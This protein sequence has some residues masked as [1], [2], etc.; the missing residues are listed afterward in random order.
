VAEGEFVPLCLLK[1][2]KSFILNLLVF[3][4]SDLPSALPMLPPV[5]LA[6]DLVSSSI[7]EL[8]GRNVPEL[9]FKL[10]ESTLILGIPTACS[11]ESPLTMLVPRVLGDI[12]ILPV[13]ALVA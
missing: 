11:V 1:K 4:R 10:A 6:S 8:S 9:S 7:G 3:F 12:G 2:G 13:V 5:V